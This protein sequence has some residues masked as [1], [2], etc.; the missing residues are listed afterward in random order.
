MLPKNKEACTA[1]PLQ[2]PRNL[3]HEANAFNLGDDED[4]L[5]DVP[6][7]FVVTADHDSGRDDGGPS[8]RRFCWSGLVVVY[9]HPEPTRRMPMRHDTAFE[10]ASVAAG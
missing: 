2:K 1:A 9:D 7:S 10:D 3:E 4:D 5:Y 8:G 6:A